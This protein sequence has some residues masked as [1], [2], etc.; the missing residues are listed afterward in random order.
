ADPGLRRVGRRCLQG[1]VQTIHPQQIGEVVLPRP[2]TTVD[3]RLHVIAETLD[4]QAVRG[5]PGCRRDTFR[6]ADP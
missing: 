2:H 6:V 5:V 1:E 4:R 3:H